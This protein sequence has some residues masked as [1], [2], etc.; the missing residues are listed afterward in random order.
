M[1]ALGL[2]G[3]VLPF[4]MALVLACTYASGK[5]LSLFDEK[6]KWIKFGDFTAVDKRWFSIYYELGI[7]GLSLIMMV[8]T[9]LLAML[10]AIAAFTIKKNLK[11]FYMLLLMLEIG[12]LG[13]FAAQN[14]M[15]FFIF[16]EITL[17]PM[18]LLIGKWGNCRVKR[19]LIVI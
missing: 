11:A 14:L 7:D 15:L 16:F 1:R 18:F 2:F 17:P 10:A 6:V 3:T 5:S 8:L 19:L 12:M 4:G 13:V 9:A